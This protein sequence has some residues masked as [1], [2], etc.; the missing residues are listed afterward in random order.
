VQLVVRVNSPVYM[1]CTGDGSHQDCNKLYFRGNNIDIEW[2]L[3]KQDGLPLHYFVCC[4]EHD[5]RELKSLQC[6]LI[7]EVKNGRQIVVPALNL[8]LAFYSR[9]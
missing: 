2:I 7:R 8:P 4:V 9:L 5:A 3:P 1:Y 6:H